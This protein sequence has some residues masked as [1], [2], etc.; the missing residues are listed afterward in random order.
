MIPD[1]DRLPDEGSLQAEL[2]GLPRPHPPWGFR[3]RLR[4]Q[5]VRDEFPERARR[6]R[7]RRPAWG[8]VALAGGLAAAL[9]ALGLFANRGPSWKLVA[10]SGSG[11]A[12]VDGRDVPL[13][14]RALLERRLRRGARVRLPA[15]A[16]LDLE[17]PGIALLQMAGGEARLPGGPGRWFARSMS[18]SLV[19]GELR[20]ATGPGFAGARLT[21]ATPEARAI[22]TG[23]TLSVLRDREA[24]CVCVFE[25][26]VLMTGAGGPDTVR[27]G[28]RR[29]VYRGGTPPLLEPIL[30]ME[31][32]KLGMLRDAARQTLTREP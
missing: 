11:T 9:L 18:A 25:G 6:P 20:I 8:D 14:E 29:S 15:G 5:F 28:F 21:V 31:S 23:T 12:R 19:S 22:V 2:R 17:L 26:R 30:P 16:Q 1:R 7:P 24:S 10:T 13:G 3:D 32:M 4:R 27:A